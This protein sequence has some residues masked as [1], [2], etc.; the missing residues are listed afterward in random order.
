MITFYWIAE[1]GKVLLGYLLVMYL[2]PSLVFRK[3]LAGKIQDL[4]FQL[5]CHGT[6]GDHKYPCFNP[7]PFAYFKQMGIRPYFLWDFALFSAWKA[8]CLESRRDKASV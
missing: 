2:W 6:D 1:Y 4:S 8:E 7:G 3:H 5:L